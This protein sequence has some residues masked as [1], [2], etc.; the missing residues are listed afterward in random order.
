MP[1]A[2]P[3]DSYEALT[4]AVFLVDN[5]GCGRDA[6]PMQLAALLAFSLFGF[7]L[8]G[9][10]ILLVVLTVASIWKMRKDSFWDEPPG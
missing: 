3:V 9:G 5:E 1:S 8:I 7:L 4:E 6:G 10:I 2:G